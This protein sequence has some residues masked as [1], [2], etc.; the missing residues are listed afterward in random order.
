MPGLAGRNH[1]VG[2]GGVAAAAQAG[3]PRDGQRRARDA[4]EGEEVEEQRPS[5]DA[6]RHAQRPPDG[7]RPG[8]ADATADSGRRRGLVLGHRGAGLGLAACWHDAFVSAGLVARSSRRRALSAGGAVV[9]VNTP[10]V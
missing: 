2:G 5:H 3:R 6:G 1:G 9:T 10:T 8:A 7:G 4:E